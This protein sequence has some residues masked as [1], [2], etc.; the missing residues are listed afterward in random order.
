VKGSKQI[1]PMRRRLA[2]GLK[3]NLHTAGFDSCK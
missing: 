2:D 3:N 1:L